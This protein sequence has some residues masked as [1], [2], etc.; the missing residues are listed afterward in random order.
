[1]TLLLSYS[2]FL[3]LCVKHGITKSLLTSLSP[4]LTDSFTQVDNHN[5]D[6]YN[7]NV[8][9]NHDIYNQFNMCAAVISVHSVIGAYNITTQ[10]HHTCYDNIVIYVTGCA[11]MVFNS[12][13]LEDH[14]LA[15]KNHTSL[16]F[17]LFLLLFCFTVSSTEDLTA[18]CPDAH[19]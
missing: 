15:L 5:K 18:T 6:D 4:L 13:S 17:S 8:D 2:L 19:H 1:M 10:C 9:R 3:Y 16:K 14:N 11:K 7:H 12:M